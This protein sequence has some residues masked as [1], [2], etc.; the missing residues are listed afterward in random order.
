[1]IE[2]KFFDKLIDHLINSISFRVKNSYEAL[3]AREENIMNLGSQGPHAKLTPA[4]YNNLITCLGSNF[5]YC[6]DIHYLRGTNEYFFN[7]IYSNR[8]K[9]KLRNWWISR[10]LMVV[11][12]ATYVVVLLYH[13]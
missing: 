2:L 12:I 1:M 3:L 10:S 4:E 5:T 13:R 7:R 9:I 11:L 8:V 6:V